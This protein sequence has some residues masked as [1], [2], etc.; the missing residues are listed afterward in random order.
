MGMGMGFVIIADIEVEAEAEA[1]AVV[2]NLDTVITKTLDTPL[3]FLTGREIETETAI[4]TIEDMP[5]PHLRDQDQGHDQ[6]HDTGTQ[7]AGRAD[8]ALLF[9]THGRGILGLYHE[10]AMSSDGAIVVVL[11][12][13]HGHAIGVGHGHGHDHRVR[14]VG[15]ESV[16]GTGNGSGDDS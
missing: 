4:A 1:G 14:C 3:P 15:G 10:T 12:T 13:E 7:T 8:H 16:T 11:M 6:G 2:M 5:H 9:Q